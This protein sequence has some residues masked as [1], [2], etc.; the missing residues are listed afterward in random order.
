MKQH[1]LPSLCHKP[2]AQAKETTRS[3][4]ACASGLWAAA[5]VGNSGEMA[6]TRCGGRKRC[7]DSSL[8]AV[9]SE[10]GDRGNAPMK[11]TLIIIGSLGGLYAAFGIFQ[12]IRTL[13]ESDPGTTIGGTEIAASVVPVC[14]GLILCL[15]CFQRAFRKP[16]TKGGSTRKR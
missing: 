14:L 1:V 10:S 8:V 7:Y 6:F 2:E 15:A 11:A 12:F 13:M 4:F 16:P 3:S 5:W 9:E